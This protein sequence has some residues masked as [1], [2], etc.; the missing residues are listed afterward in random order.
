[1]NTTLKNI[2][3]WITN[4]HNENEAATIVEYAIMLALI[5]L[6]AIAAIV[7]VGQ[8]SHAFWDNSATELDNALN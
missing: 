5:V 1:M 2:A 6:F 8:E 7:T 4:F 3:R